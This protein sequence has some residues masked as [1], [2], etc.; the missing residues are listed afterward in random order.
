M[1][2]ALWL[3][4]TLNHPFQGAVHVTPDAFRTALQHIEY[5]R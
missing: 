2:F 4:A 1:A 5:F 3:V